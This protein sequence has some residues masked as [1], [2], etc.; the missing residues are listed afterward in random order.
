MT[1]QHRINNI[2]ISLNE[3]D[4]NPPHVHVSASGWVVLVN[5]RTGEIMAKGG[6]VPAK[7]LQVALAWI[8]ENKE[9][10]LTKWEEREG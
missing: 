3:N 5:I 4:H 8:A 7:A 10:L 2:K 9:T 1:T 6:K